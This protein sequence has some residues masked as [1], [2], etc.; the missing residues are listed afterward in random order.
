MWPV[1]SPTWIL[2]TLLARFKA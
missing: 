2:N 1:G